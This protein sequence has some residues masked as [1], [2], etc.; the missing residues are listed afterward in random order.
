MFQLTSQSFKP[1]SWSALVLLCAALL[2]AACVPV[3]V[4]DASQTLPSDADQTVPP[5]NETEAAEAASDM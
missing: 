4:S 1:L 5:N 2:V 3:T